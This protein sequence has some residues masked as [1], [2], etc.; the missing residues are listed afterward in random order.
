MKAALLFSFSIPLLSAVGYATSTLVEDA[1]Q[2]RALK[3]GIDLYIVDAA[4][5]ALTAIADIYRRN[6]VDHSDP[7]RK[8]DLR[9]Q[10]TAQHQ[11][12]KSIIDVHCHAIPEWYRLISPYSGGLPSGS[13]MPA[14]NVTAHL[15]FM[16][17]VGISHSVLGFTS[18]SANAYLGD[19][20]RTVTLARLINEYLA[21]LSRAF[22]HKFSFLA[23]IPLPYTEESI[24]ELSYATNDLGAIGVALMSNHEG[25]Y[26]GYDVFTPFWRAL[27]GLSGRQ[28][29]YVHPTTPYIQVNSS[30]LPANPYPSMSQSRME[31]YMETARTFVDLTIEQ[32]IHN[33]TNT[34]FILPHVGG[35]FPTMIDRVLKTV[36][37]ELYDSSLEIYR[38]RFWWD[39]AGPTYYHQIDG[40]LAYGVPKANLLFGSDY[41]FIE[42]GPAEN[43]LEAIMDYPGLTFEEKD[44]LLYNNSKRLFGYRLPCE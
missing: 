15:N 31:F 22:P 24:R 37:P 9:T 38:T 23:S 2:A 1:I 34:H 20:K 16:A 13:P 18:P 11:G 32:T 17:T 29:A 27:N 44:S 30:F 28:V 5:E 42:E 40:L 4:P 36:N 33:F 35:A 8:R 43:Y 6:D 39:S 41:P 12:V 26:L 19:Q 7:P 21:A 10:K 25:H 3:D 14:W